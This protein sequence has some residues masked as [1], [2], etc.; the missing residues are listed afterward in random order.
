[1]GF[2]AGIPVE[3]LGH[4]SR[5]R[6]PRS[7]RAAPAGARSAR[8]RRSGR[9]RAG[10]ARRG[11]VRTAVRDLIDAGAKTFA[12]A[13]LWS[14]R[15]PAHEERVGEIIRELAPGCLRQSVLRS[16][17]DHRRV[18]AHRHD[19]AQLLS[20]AKSRRLSRP[21][22][23]PAARARLS[24]QVQRA[25]FGRRRR[26][27]ERSG[28][29]AGVAG[30]ERSGR[31]RHGLAATRAGDRP[32]Q[33]HHHRHGRHELRR[34]AGRRRQAA[35]FRHPRGRRLSSQH[36]GHRHS[37]HRRRRRLDRPRARPACCGSDRTAPAPCPVR[38]ATAAAA[39][40]PPSPTPIWF[41]ASSTRTISS[42]AA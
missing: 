10:A 36:A 18:R 42:A 8:A 22:R 20:R 33:R 12:V 5:R 17:A 29:Q 15:N 13:L 28:A 23:K 16:V 38:S 21:H 7:D 11:S 2:T 26:S 39:S 27:G 30:G 37:R 9:A 4:Y 3:N 19:G 1:M 6:Y 25:Q 14:F 34:R 40:S 31:R 24:R 41:S 35:R 32:Q